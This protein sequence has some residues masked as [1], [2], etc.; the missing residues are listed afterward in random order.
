MLI[1][2]DKGGREIRMESECGTCTGYTEEC[3]HSGLWDFVDEKTGRVCRGSCDH[4][5]AYGV[6]QKADQQLK[7]A[8]LS[9]R[10]GQRRLD[11]FVP[12]ND[13]TEAALEK[14]KAWCEQDHSDGVGLILAGPVGTGKTHL[15]AGILNQWLDAGVLGTFGL[16][17]D[18][19]GEI[20]EAIQDNSGKSADQ[21]IAELAK[22]PLLIFDDFGSSKATEFQAATLF[23]I[24]NARYENLLPTIITTNLTA[25][26]IRDF[27]GSRIYSRLQEVC[28]WVPVEGD[29]YRKKIADERKK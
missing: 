29:D 6:R 27:L 7:N 28:Y 21:I 14:C 16:T 11:N 20:R 3:E 17:S 9:T 12:V 22:T 15:A 19:F 10:F 4:R 5:R 2:H 25:P 8:N 1:G 18:I 23:R 24:Q 26:E 13:S